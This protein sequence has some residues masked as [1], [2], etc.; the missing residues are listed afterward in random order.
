MTIVVILLHTTCIYKIYTEYTMKKLMILF[1]FIVFLPITVVESKAMEGVI[2]TEPEQIESGVFVAESH[3][4]SGEKIYL[5]MELLT[6]ENSPCWIQYKRASCC[7]G[8]SNGRGVLWGLAFTLVQGKFP[9]YNENMKVFTGFTEE[10]Y[11][12]FIDFLLARKIQDN[13]KKVN[14]IKHTSDGANHMNCQVE[15]GNQYILYVS[16]TPDFSITQVPLKDV[17][18]FVTLKEYIEWYSNILMCVGSDFSEDGYFHTRGIFKN[19]YI[20]IE[21]GYS[22]LSKILHGF[23]GAVA[24]KFFPDKVIMEVKAISSMQYIL[25]TTLKPG[26]GY[27][28]EK[29]EQ[30]DVIELLEETRQGT[31]EAQHPTN[32]IKVDALARIYYTGE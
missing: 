8:N 6:D 11:N 17:D 24:Q 28:I 5:R 14:A 29:G 22:G 19:P 31:A 23:S 12:Q 27:F 4:P 25:S 10:E 21:G 9:E 32:Y 15:K 1:F 18:S 20:F 13:R 3:V 7:M 16:K 26:D 2:S 30:K